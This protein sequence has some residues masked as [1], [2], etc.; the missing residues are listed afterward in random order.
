MSNEPESTKNPDERLVLIHGFSREETIAIMR[1]AKSVTADPQGIAFT[2]STPSN[3]EW[4]L[5]DV[6]AEVREEHEYMRNNPP[7][8]NQTPQ[9]KRSQGSSQEQS[10]EER[11]E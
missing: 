5:R 1:A 3:I 10:S 2:T 6:I 7:Q 8:P 9:T 11:A 4:K